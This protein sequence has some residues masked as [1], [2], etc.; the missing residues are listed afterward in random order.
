MDYRLSAFFCVILIVIVAAI[1]YEQVKVDREK[2]DVIDSMKNAW[3]EVVKTLTDAGDA[4][5]HVFKPTERSTL[6][7]LADS[8]KGLTQ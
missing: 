2:R 7:K 6:D 1:P 4:V 8:V 3:T 5:V